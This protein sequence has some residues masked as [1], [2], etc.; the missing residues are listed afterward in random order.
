MAL[1]LGPIQVVEGPKHSR[2]PSCRS[3][4]IDDREK[5]I[6][7]PGADAAILQKLNEQQPISRVF[8]SHYHFDH[9]RGNGLFPTAE[10]WINEWE[11][12]CFMDRR[13][14]AKRVGILEVW[15]EAGVDEWLQYIQ[16]EDPPQTPFS[17]SRNPLWFS[18][19][20]R[21]DG[22]YADGE[23]FDFGEVKME[24]INSPGHTEG[25]CCFLFPQQRAVYSPD[26]DLTTW[27]P[28]YGGSDSNIDL[29]INSARALLFLDVDWIITGHEAG[30]VSKVDYATQV[31]DYLA[32][33]DRREDLI[34]DAL[35]TP[36][37]LDQ[38]TA[39]GIIYGGS[40]Y[41]EQ[42]PWVF[43]WEKVSLVH[44]LERALQ[45]GRVGYLDGQFF[46]IEVN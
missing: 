32:I 1:D 42:D 5:I 34:L 17:P 13:N 35:Q 10:I 45:Q 44:H 8:C 28:W 3:L 46:A 15:G 11:G 40:Q 29:F 30:I 22:T 24:V 2:F 25:H 31:E 39:K 14:V 6:I 4:F 16:Q 36:M 37:S 7:D 27:G 19:T 21:L 33:I 9:I 38:L 12:E 26:I 23:V 18:A 20:S 43:A 41:V